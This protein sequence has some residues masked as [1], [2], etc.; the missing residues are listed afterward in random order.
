[1]TRPHGTV[2][3]ASFTLERVYAATP[4]R[5]FAA[6]SD[7][8]A[9]RRWFAEGEGFAVVDYSLDFRVGGR[10]QARFAFKGGPEGAPP[11]GTEMGN[12]T[13]YLDLVPERR[14]V[15]AYVMLV[16]GARISAS[17]ATV[18]FAAADGGT[19]LT[20]TEQAAF[21][22]GADGLELREQGWRALLEALAAEL[23]RA[24]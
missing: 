13:V 20:F 15:F 19:R 16:A 8:T 11:A 3:H 1:M 14:V 24:V 22:E 18:E 6:F 4:A 10:E 12:E 2:V 5:V 17:L 7:P 21:F 23:Q 9:K